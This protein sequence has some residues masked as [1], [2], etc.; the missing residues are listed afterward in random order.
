MIKVIELNNYEE[1]DY[2]VAK[3]LFK[4]EETGTMLIFEENEDEI[5]LKEEDLLLKIN[6]N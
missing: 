1:E 6:S 5:W 3:I 4:T 2:I